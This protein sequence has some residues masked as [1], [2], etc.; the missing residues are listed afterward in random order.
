LPA[1]YVVTLPAAAVIRVLLA[2]SAVALVVVDAKTEVVVEA[3]DRTVAAPPD[4]D[5]GKEPTP[6]GRILNVASLVITIGTLPIVTVV[7][8]NV[9]VSVTV[10]RNDFPEELEPNMVV[11]TEDELG[12]ATV[13]VVEVLTLP[14]LITPLDEPLVPVAVG[15][16]QGPDASL[17]MVQG[18]RGQM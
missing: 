2:L 3:P 6:K 10:P 17:V 11:G 4:A 16:G 5:A 1:R 9:V 14:L 8:L 7:G 13:V 12:I 15:V 18:L